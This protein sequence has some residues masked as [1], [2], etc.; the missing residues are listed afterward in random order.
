[1]DSICAG[2]IADMRVV[3]GRVKGHTLQAPR[4]METRPTSDKVREALFSMLAGDVMDQRVLDLFAGTGA[5]AIEALSRGAA[6][7]VLIERRPAACQVIRANLRHTRLETEA[8]LMC[9]PAER[10]I[11]LL[12]G[13]F[14]LVLLDPPYAYTGIAGIM[15][16]I[17]AGEILE[18]DA[19]VVLEHSPRFT[20]A[21]RYERLVRQRQRV[22]GD[23]ALSFFVV[24]E[25]EH[26]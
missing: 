5:L 14:G 16:M 25:D 15:T 1:M 10:A 18:E 11:S 4:G 26:A 20:V 12:E 21:E 22:Y 8:R 6:E 2:N 3:A 23:T 7:A 24:R 19:I 9:M 17:G 13:K